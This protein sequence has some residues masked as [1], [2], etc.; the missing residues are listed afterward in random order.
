[1]AQ[2]IVLNLTKELSVTFNDAAKI[3]KNHQDVQVLDT[4]PTPRGKG[5]FLIEAPET[6]VNDL[7]HKLKG[8]IISPN[9]PIEASW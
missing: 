6:A 8:W 5:M 3:L 7:T 2:F 4:V 1:M 9:R